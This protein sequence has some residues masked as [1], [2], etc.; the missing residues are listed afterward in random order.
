MSRPDAFAGIQ[1][2]FPSARA[3][4]ADQRAFIVRVEG[5]YR[6]DGNGIFSASRLNLLAGS[7]EVYTQLDD[8]CGLVP[9]ML[10]PNLVVAGG[11]VR[12]NVCFVVRAADVDSL[13]LTD[14]VGNQSERPYFT[15]R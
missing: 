15:V 5:T 1:K 6:G 8:A 13:V 12:G 3:P 4:A 14:T 7:G 10:P 2:E 11:Q 9:D